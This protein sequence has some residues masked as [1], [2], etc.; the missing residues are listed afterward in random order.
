MATLAARGAHLGSV[1]SVAAAHMIPGVSM[2]A[3]AVAP[4]VVQSA[5]QAALARPAVA[6]KRATTARA[7]RAKARVSGSP[8]DIGRALSSA[9]GWGGRQ[10]AC[11]DALWSKESDWLV[12]ADNPTSSAYGIPQALPG[13]KMR[14]HG[15]D[16]R[17]NPATQIRWGLD[18]I[19]DVYG[20]PCK[21]W[22]HSRAHNWY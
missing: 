15:D 19:D 21:A 4:R 2:T 18:Y 7:S 1:A 12:T 11:L 5:Q 17:T 6:T 16:W 22:S 14:T 9:R 13:R 3:F 8:R 10:F 20:T